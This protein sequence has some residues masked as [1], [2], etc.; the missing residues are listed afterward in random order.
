MPNSQKSERAQ[1]RHWLIARLTNRPDSEH[2]LTLSRL[3][4]SMVAF[5]AL[6]IGY[7]G[8]SE[9]HRLFLGKI[10]IYF[11]AFTGATLF[12]FV[13]LLIYPG[14]SRFRRLL[15]IPI[16]IGC[17]AYLMHSGDE[18]TA[19]TYPIFLWAIFGN[20]F[21]FGVKYL[22][23]AAIVGF[24]AFLAVI[25][26]TPFW[27]DNRELSGG[28]LAGLI[29]LPVYVSVLIRRLSEAK[30]QAEEASRA[31]SLFL[32][33]L[34]HEL[35]T[36]L[37]AVI[38]LSDMLAGA[39]LPREQADMAR[40]IGKSGRSL[41]NLINSLLDLSRMEIGKKPQM[42]VFALHEML[43]DIRDMLNVQARAKGIDLVLRLDPHLP[44][45][46]QGSM[47]HFEEVLINLV[48][49]AVKF[50][51]QGSVRID[52]RVVGKSD[53][54]MRL[55]LEVTDTGIGIAPEAQARIFESFTQADETIIDR[56]GGTGLGL[57]IARQLVV[58]HDGEIGVESVLG[59][60]STFW[61][62]MQVGT[63]SEDEI[64]AQAPVAPVR[65]I[66][67][68]RILVAEDNRTNQMVIAQI[69]KQDGHEAVMVENGDLAV[70]ALLQETFD[71]VLMDLNMPVM[72][73]LDAAKFYAFA[74]VG[75]DRV[76]VIALTADATAQTAEKCRAAG[77]VDCLNKPI[78]PQAL[79]DAVA[80]YA[81]K[82]APVAVAS[83]QA[84]PDEAPVSAEPIDPRAL[85]DLEKLGGK[86]FVSEIVA[87]FISDA[88]LVLQNLGAA[89]QA[90]DVTGFRDHAHALRSCA[91]NV[92]AQ[93]VYRR[94][95]DLRDIDEGELARAGLSHVRA[96]E[97][98]FAS[99]CGILRPL[100]QAA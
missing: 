4:L 29:I 16:D 6:F 51:S 78:E 57:A 12:L 80:Q 88:A 64:V 1:G 72:N 71:L 98:D 18:L 3:A 14:V 56:F 92:G 65:S 61:F 83:T 22:F 96:L 43:H 59:Q 73:G 85:S 67:P 8:G 54:T 60:G 63:V 9:E 90:Q 68:L 26:T 27:R 97:R 42:G 94:C 58:A 93:A 7:L 48:G 34:S 24:L 55:R 74:M 35:R 23:I 37:N 86:T 47:R 36:P 89:V 45:H 5:L 2:E 19:F 39:Q 62:E 81:L 53:E 50:T 44:Q 32:A 91:A 69:L 52:A 21:R 99:A 28:L 100:V 15:G 76:P 95:L 49:N 40:T 84:T 10:G 46:V 75:Q 87:Q 20:G 17:V 66:R 79:L 30:R 31:K 13:H 70:E 33:S 25:V 11:I 38:G 41:L 82:G 77:M